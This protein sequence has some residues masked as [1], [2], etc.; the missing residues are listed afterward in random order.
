MASPKELAPLVPDTLP[1]DFNEWDGKS[2]VAP[3]SVKSGERDAWEA[4]DPFGETQKPL[5]Q[6]GER[7]ALIASL[8]DGSR[9]S[10]SASSAPSF[11]KQ[12]EDLIDWDSEA[13]PAPWPVDRTEWEEWEATHSFGKP[14]GQSAGREAFLSPAADKT[15]DSGAA[16]SAPIIAKQQESTNGSV[17]GTSNGASHKPE[18]RNAT[19]EVSAAPVSSKAASAD[20]ASKSSEPAATTRRKADE[21]VYQLFSPKEGEVKVEKKTSKKKWMTVAGIS[22]GAIL[23]PLAILIPLLHHGTKPVPTPSVQPLPGATTTEVTT[24][25]PTPQASSKPTAQGKPQTTTE[26]QQT[27]D[28]QPTSEEQGSTPVP[29]Q[30]TMMNNQLTA[31]TRI[32]KQEAENTPPPSSSDTASADGLGGGNANVSMF[33]GHGQPT[34]KVSRPVAISSGVATGML[35]QRTPPDYPPLA[36]TAHVAG[37]VELHATI[38][39]NGTIKDLHAV[40][41]PV[42]LRQAALDAVRN[43]RYKPYKLNDQPVEVETTINVVFTLGG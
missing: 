18:A 23:L 14:P 7:D 6:S 37:T 1:E 10:G 15:S 24:S 17:D 26:K 31:P 25:E 5:W 43:W 9:A 11:L 41:G 27:T 30:P 29:V 34:V 32:P 21:A 20:G 16:A 22:A 33:S 13:T 28:N 42:M 8:V 4:T 19:N 40:S 3:S 38:S 2:A 12:Q 35:I 36:K 39:T